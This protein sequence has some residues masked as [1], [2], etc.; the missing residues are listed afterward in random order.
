MQ[1]PYN[2]D[3]AEESTAA[4]LFQRHA[5]ALL[6]YLRVH[7]PSREDAEDLLVDTFLA[8]LEQ[9][10]FSQMA[11]KEQ[12]YW[13]RR[14]AHNKMVDFYRRLTRRYAQTVPLEDVS[15]TT[16]DDEEVGPELVSL[17]N[18]EYAR[19]QSS[20][21]DLSEA[22]QELLRLRFGEGLR[23]T[24]IAVRLGKRDSTVRMMLSRTLNLLRTIYEK[25]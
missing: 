12:V 17:R 8:A 10:S 11:E 15:D 19:L 3:V 2:L 4:I 18:E 14:V 23:S 1:G 21:A 13:L 7:T 20:L 25:H 16:Y 5:P 9:A 24:E 6:S 22:Q